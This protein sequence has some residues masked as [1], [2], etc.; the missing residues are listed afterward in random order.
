[1]KPKGLNKYYDHV[2]MIFVMSKYGLTVHFNYYL[3]IYRY[4]QKCW[5][6]MV[7]QNE[8]NPAG[9]EV[10]L[11]AMWKHPFGD[12]SSCSDWCTHKQ[13]PCKQYKQL[14]F[15]Q[16]LTDKNL[17]EALAAIFRKY[18]SHS[19][20]IAELGST[21]ANESINNSIASKAPKRFHYS[22]SASLNYRVSAAVAQKNI[23]HT[24]VS[25]VDR[26]IDRYHNR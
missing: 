21:Q 24:Y 2:T 6:Y 10:G 11:D 13:D 19:K 26:Y 20:K 25:K 16:C 23:G 3:Q 12:H 9:I 8:H 14:P 7:A 17:Q 22:G 15:G 18:K 1:M 5:A 4:I